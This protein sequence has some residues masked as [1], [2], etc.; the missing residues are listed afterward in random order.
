MENS[1]L[2]HAMYF[3][4]DVKFHFRHKEGVFKSF[5]I[6]IDMYGKGLVDMNYLHHEVSGLFE[7]HP[8]L[9]EP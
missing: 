5:V 3:M 6:A 9:L 8:N 7:D 4:N 1:E 2:M